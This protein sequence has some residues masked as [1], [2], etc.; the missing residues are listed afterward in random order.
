MNKLS[1]FIIVVIATLLIRCEKE[2]PITKTFKAKFVAGMCGQI[3]I[4]ILDSN[5]YDKGMNWTNSSG[6]LYHHVFTVRN[7]CDLNPSTLNVGGDIFD[8]V[9]IASPDKTNC[10]TCLA[11]METPPKTWN[12]KVKK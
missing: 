11:Y 10:I 6:Q 5:Y 1:T 4:E 9:L 7:P 2:Q 8:C 3:I 12:I